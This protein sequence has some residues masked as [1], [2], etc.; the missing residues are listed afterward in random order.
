[1]L[2]RSR[3]PTWATRPQRSLSIAAS[4]GRI[5]IEACLGCHQ[6]I[7]HTFPMLAAGR[8]TSTDE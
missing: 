5:Q 4:T 1:M 7:C 3:W 2:Q 6:Q 8:Q